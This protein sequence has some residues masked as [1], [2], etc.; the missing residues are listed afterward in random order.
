MIFSSL[1][2]DSSVYELIDVFLIIKN[3]LSVTTASTAA[4]EEQTDWEI[5]TPLARGIIGILCPQGV[6]CCP[7]AGGQKAAEN[8]QEAE[9]TNDPE[10]I[11]VKE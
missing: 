9:N 4:I 8:T 6:F 11:G 7:R 1:S 5:L 3:C 10:G 2:F